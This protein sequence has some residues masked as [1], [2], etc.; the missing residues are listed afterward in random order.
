MA[1]PPADRVEV[2]QV[3]LFGMP[4]GWQAYLNHITPNCMQIVWHI[5]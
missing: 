1:H 2:T 4:F 3:P 5:P